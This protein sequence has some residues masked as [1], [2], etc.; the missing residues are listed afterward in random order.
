VYV[1]E[2]A[3]RPIGGLC[4]KAL[5]FE[6]PGREV[7]SLEEVLLRHALGEDVSSYRRE[8]QRQG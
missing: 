7:V 4:S 5:R 3:P 8:A 2:V 1:L 6:G